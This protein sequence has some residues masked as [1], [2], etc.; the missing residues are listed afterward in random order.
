[1]SDCAQKTDLHVSVSDHLLVRE[2]AVV[3]RAVHQENTCPDVSPRQYLT[4]MSFDLT[5]LALLAAATETCGSVEIRENGRKI[6]MKQS[7]SALLASAVLTT[8]MS[9]GA[10]A[11]TLVPCGSVENNVTPN[12]SCFGLLDLSDGADAKLNE[13]N[14]LNIN[15]TGSW[16][17]LGQF[18]NV[19][20]NGFYSLDD[21]VLDDRAG[22][23]TISAFATTLYNEF[24]MVFKSGQDANTTPASF[25]GYILAGTTGIWSSPFTSAQGATRDLSNVELYGRSSSSSPSPIPLPAAGWLLLAGLGCIAAVRSRSKST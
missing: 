25:V 5:G 6:A 12:S 7:I 1:M 13:L 14:L 21:S 4:N 2:P 19:G 3:K 15:G 18:E 17:S 8:F 20:S 23:W 10:N 24:M 9:V 22:V 11:A 16:S